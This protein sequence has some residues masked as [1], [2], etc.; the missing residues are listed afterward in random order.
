MRSVADQ[1][2]GTVKNLRA[3]D[4]ADQV[5]DAMDSLT[6][7]VAN[8]VRYLSS[9]ARDWGASTDG[10]VRASPW[11][12]AGAVALLAIAAGMLVS[13]GARRARARA[14]SE[15]GREDAEVYRG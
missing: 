12:A 11:R 6:D 2:I 7:Q 15:A 4:V 5:S 1:T 14:T 3:Q 13:R 8:G 9:K 10:L